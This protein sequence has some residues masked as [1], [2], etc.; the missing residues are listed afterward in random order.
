MNATRPAAIPDGNPG[1]GT[2]LFSGAGA[3]HRASAS[4]RGGSTSV[5]RLNACSRR[6]AGDR[7]RRVGVEEPTADGWADAGVVDVGEGLVADRVAAGVQRL[8]DE[9][10]GVL[11]A[12]VHLV[13]VP[14]LHFASE[15]SAQATPA[16]DP[17]DGRHPD[18]TSPYPPATA[19]RLQ[20]S[21]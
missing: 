4:G 20:P 10:G 18:S 13:A 16:S 6:S 1:Q 8:P 19:V 2:R 12:E 15:R 17:A 11:G 14:S 5:S 9:G 7:V 21:A 3:G